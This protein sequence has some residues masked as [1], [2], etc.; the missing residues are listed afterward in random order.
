MYDLHVKQ[1]KRPPGKYEDLSAVTANAPA[2]AAPDGR[3]KVYWG[4]S[5][6][7]TGTAVLAHDAAAESKG[8][9]VLLTDCKTVKQMTAEEFKAAPKAGKK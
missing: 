7:P 5:V 2:T 3:L 8:G 1:V 6:S 4:A 9:W